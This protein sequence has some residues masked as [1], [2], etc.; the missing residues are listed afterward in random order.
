M[1][2]VRFQ[3]TTVNIIEVLMSSKYLTILEAK[4]G[5]K[6]GDA[7][8]L[9]LKFLVTDKI[10]LNDPE[11]VINSQSFNAVAVL[12][13]AHEKYL[14]DNDSRLLKRENLRRVLIEYVKM[15]IKAGIESGKFVSHDMRVEVNC[16][17]IPPNLDI[18]KA[19]LNQPEEVIV[20]R[21]F[22]FPR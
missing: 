13:R 2:F 18:S 14:T 4:W 16:R 17:F 7:R 1:N 6:T 10:I 8:K 5:P 19:I 9:Y 11:Q 22:G 20:E 12:Y 21:R 3:P 15:I